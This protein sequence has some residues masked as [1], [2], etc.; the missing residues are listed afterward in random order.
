MKFKI[1]SKRATAG[2]ALIEYLLLFSFMTFISISMVKG[3]G[4]TM[5]SSVGIMGYELTEQ[6]TV[7]VCEH[8]CFFTG[9]ENQGKD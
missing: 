6:F 7:G 3:L 2:Q 1:K 4:K 5:L 8:L 9:Y